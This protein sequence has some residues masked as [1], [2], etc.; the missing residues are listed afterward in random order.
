VKPKEYLKKVK[1]S[2][3]KDVEISLS[4][5][6]ANASRASHSTLP[7]FIDMQ[8]KN[9]EVLKKA[10]EELDEYDFAYYILEHYDFRN[11]RMGGELGD[12]FVETLEFIND[13]H[14]LF[15]DYGMRELF[16]SFSISPYFRE[17][18][19][20]IYMKYKDEIRM[21]TKMVNVEEKAGALVGAFD[22]AY[23]RLIR[24]EFEEPLIKYFLE[25]E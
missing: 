21:D 9:L 22:R 4:N 13:M 25:H 8:K 24:V 23:R 19:I 2:F 10:L 1:V 12:M 16:A 7:R 11:G 5:L 14:E 3:L 17:E 20:N 6:L 18:L 15:P